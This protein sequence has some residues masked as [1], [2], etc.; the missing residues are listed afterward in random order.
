M[1]S[2]FSDDLRYAARSLRRTPGFAAVA[3]LTLG[4]GIGAS[5]SIF[6]VAYDPGRPLKYAGSLMVCLG[7]T[8]MFY[9]KAYF[10]K[11]RKRRVATA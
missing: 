6:S 5:S 2:N 8:T 3:I 4:V 1:L 9:M 7:I 11:P 10:F